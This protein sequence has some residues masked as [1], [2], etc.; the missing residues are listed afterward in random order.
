MI[1]RSP[2]SSSS[3]RVRGDAASA[4]NEYSVSIPYCSSSARR[5][6]P[7]ASLPTGPTRRT[8]WPTELSPHATLAELP[9]MRH[10]SASALTWSPGAGMRRT[11]R[12]TSA[13]TTPNTTTSAMHTSPVCLVIRGWGPDGT[14]EPKVL[15][16]WGSQGVRSPCWSESDEPFLQAG[17][18]VV[19]GLQLSSGG[20]R[21]LSYAELVLLR[22]LADK[23]GQAGGLPRGA[24]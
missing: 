15:L 13:A 7:I 20:Q 11:R 9:P 17:Y 8:W 10:P 1:V 4:R 2:V 18:R 24:G 16:S 14:P 12:T 23:T 6:S 22:H 5:L 21:V 3:M 19:Q